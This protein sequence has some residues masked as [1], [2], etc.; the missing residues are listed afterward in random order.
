MPGS[1]PVLVLGYSYWQ[2]RFGGSPDI[3]GREVEIDG[4]PLTVVGVAPKGFRS[5]Y[6]A[7]IDVQAYLPINMFS[8]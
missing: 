8:S 1:D 3:I 4:Q 6:G 5:L 2:E 7:T